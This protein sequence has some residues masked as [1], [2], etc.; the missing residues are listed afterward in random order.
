[1]VFTNG[2]I[3]ANSDEFP[4]KGW[5]INNGVLTVLSAD[6]KE[7]ANGGDITKKKYKNFELELD[8]DLKEL[9]VELNTLL[10]L[11]LT[12]VKAQQMDPNIN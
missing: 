10:I 3:G 1:M 5:K 9:I 8:L 11:N 4:N 7:S 12:K 2:W 6:G